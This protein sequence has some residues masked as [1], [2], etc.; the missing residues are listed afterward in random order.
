MKVNDLANWLGYECLFDAAADEDLLRGYTSD[1]LSDVMG[2]APADSVLIT[3]QAHKNTVA[4]ASLIGAFAILICN[5][6]SVP[7]DM[8]EAARRE[9]IAI[10]SCAENQFQASGKIFQLL[11]R[12]GQESS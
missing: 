8:L 6:R 7:A 5:G 2:N 9:G 10:Y 3:I 12:P 4:V 11:K 1:L